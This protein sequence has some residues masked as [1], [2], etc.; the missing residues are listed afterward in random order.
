M[1]VGVFSVRRVPDLDVE[2]YTALNER[3]WDIVTTRRDFGLIGVTG[4]KS[5]DGRSLAMAFFET[6]EGMLA[7]KREVEHA[8]AQQRGRDEFFIDYWGF[9][10]EMTDAYEF[11]KAA[12]RQNVALDSRWQPAGFEGP[13]TP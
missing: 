12:G 11:T 5:D 6:R 1:V 3:M 4:Y 8:A 10:A 13:E 2:T 9:A 7:W